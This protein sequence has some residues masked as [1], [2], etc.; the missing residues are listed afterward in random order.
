MP[1]AHPLHRFRPALWFAALAL[2]L[3]GIEHFVTRQPAFGQHRALPLAVLFDVLVGLPTL[4]YI[5]VVRRYQWPP[6]TVLAA[7]GAGLALSHWLIP[8]A[9]LPPL[10]VLRWLPAGLELMTLGLLL[11]RARRLWRAYH[12]AVLV[13]TGFLSRIRTAVAQQMGP[14]G[15]LLL[16][17]IDMLRFAVAGWWARPAAHPNATAFS[18]HRESGFVA[19]VVVGCLGLL[20]ETAALHLLAH[21]WSPTLANWLLLFEVYGLLLLLAHGH[22]VR[23][24]PTLLT[25]GEVLVRVGFCWRVVVPRAAL[26]AV[27]PLRGDLQP[28]SET[29]NL[30]KL[31]FTA[32]NLL[33]TFAESVT[34]T[35]PY[36]IRRSARRV[37]IYLDQPR[38]FIAAAGFSS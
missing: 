38:Q 1:Y 37:A 26:V 13:E 20:I 5:L 15:Q 4:F 17:E 10:Q 11:T 14:T 12:T 16:A 31:L 36:G 19:L 24:Q 8:A 23:L 3:V 32:P 25:A 28:D 35:G 7:V 29:H 27:E 33:L 34:L 9:Q 21:H 22:A 30:A 18:S 6:N 2:L